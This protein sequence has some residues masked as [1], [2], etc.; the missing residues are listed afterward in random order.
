MG[1]RLPESYGAV[2]VSGTRRWAVK[3]P[4]GEGMIVTLSPARNEFSIGGYVLDRTGLGD[5]A[6]IIARVLR[7]DDDG[8]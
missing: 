5:L 4:N 1:S 8:T 7:G 3:L 6:N 2:G